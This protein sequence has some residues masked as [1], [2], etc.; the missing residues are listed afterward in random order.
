MLHFHA[1]LM[2]QQIFFSAVQA[3]ENIWSLNAEVDYKPVSQL[4]INFRLRGMIYTNFSDISD[5]KP[6]VEAM[7]KIRYTHRKFSVRASADLKGVSKWTSF[8]DPTFVGRDAAFDVPVLRDIITVPTTVDVGLGF[9]W[10]VSK[11]CTIFIEGNN[12][13]NMNIYNWVFYREYG[14]SF[15]AGVKIQF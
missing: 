12:L 7:L 8:A 13:A 5:C 15:T 6:P 14:A 11:K 10:Y 1:A 9:D 3:R 2:I 4:L